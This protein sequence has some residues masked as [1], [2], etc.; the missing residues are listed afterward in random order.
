[1]AGQRIKII[2]DIGAAAS[3]TTI[4]SSTISQAGAQAWADAFEAMMLAAGF[5]RTSDTGQL[6]AIAAFPGNT[7]VVGYRV[8][9]LVDEFSATSPLYLKVEFAW[10]CVGASTGSAYRLRIRQITAGLA[11]DGA[12]TLTG[13]TAL[14]FNRTATS[15]STNVANAAWVGTAKTVAWRK[16]YTTVCAVS[17]SSLAASTTDAAGS[18]PYATGEVFFAVSR[19]RDYQGNVDTSG[20]MLYGMRCASQAGNAYYNALYNITYCHR[21]TAASVLSMQEDGI[22]LLSP[23]SSYRLAADNSVVLQAPLVGRTLDDAEYR[24]DGVLAYQDQSLLNKMSMITTTG[25]GGAKSYLALGCLCHGFNKRA[26]SDIAR[27]L[28][29]AAVTI[30]LSY[31][32]F[33]LTMGLALDWSD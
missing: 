16:D 27:D 17:P 15:M 29:N 3:E 32:V 22:S 7:N 18:V 33:N 20:F 26:F 21:L 14:I 24:I 28:G 8:Y 23:A 12:G 5:A 4:I 11:T 25:P 1:M 10:T 31:M 30:Y 13:N 2:G 9:A 19:M 6:G